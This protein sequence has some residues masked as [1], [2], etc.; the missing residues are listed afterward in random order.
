M[1]EDQFISACLAGR[2]IDFCTVID[3]HGNLGPDAMFTTP[4]LALESVIEMMDR[5][6]IKQLWACANPGLY[7]YAWRANQILVRAMQDFPARFVGYFIPDETDPSSIRS[8]GERCL[9]QGFR[10]IKLWGGPT[11]D[12][13][14]YNHPNYT[15]IYE[16]A[17]VNRLP[18]LAHT[19]GV[20][21][22]DLEPAIRKYPQ[23]NFLLAHA[24]AVEREKYLQ[25]A[26]NYEN[27]YLETCFSRAP[28]GLIEYFVNNGVT[29]KVIYGSDAVYMGAEQQIGRILFA[30]ISPLDKE[31][32]LG[33]NAL[34][35]LNAQ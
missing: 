30:K 26:R 32:I 27:V 25:F 8:E 31:K 9:K 12:V 4:G 17:S 18:I 6:G 29:D 13:R 24:G 10:G 22:D 20:D 35:A 23:V 28:R 16:F 19:W 11:L 21:L 14:R 7:G 33:L 15:P 5:I 2:P 3:A 1:N 34:R